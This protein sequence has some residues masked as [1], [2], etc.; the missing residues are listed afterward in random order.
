M[1]AWRWTI[2]R[3]V[4]ALAVAGLALALTIGGVSFAGVREIDTLTAQREDLVQLDTGLTRLDTKL[5]DLT[6][7]EMAAILTFSPQAATTVKDSYSGDVAD[8][9]TT[10]AQLDALHLPADLGAPVAALKTAFT[11]FVA[12]ASTSLPQLLSIPP[13]DSTAAEAAMAEQRNRTET[14]ATQVDADRELIAQR[15]AQS[16][17]VLERRIMT[18]QTTIVVAMVVGLLGLSVLSLW[19]TRLISRPVR[20]MVTALQGLAERD[21]TVSVDVRGNDEI[22]LMGTALNGAVSSVRQTVETLAS[23]STTLTAAATHLGAVSAELGDSA[24]R[25]ATQTDTIA[26]SAHQVAGSAGSM[27]AAT[28]QMSASITEIAG[29]ATRAS[30]VAGEAVRTAHE[31][32]EAVRDLG[33]ASNEIEEIVQAITSIAAQTNL[34]ALNA[35]IEAARAGDAGKGFAVVANEVK[36][37]AQETARA[38]E[39]ITSKITA[40]QSTTGRA[41]DAIARITQVIDQINENQTTIA[42]AVEEQTA[43]TSEITRNVS[44]VSGGSVHIAGTIAEIAESAASTSTSAAATQRSANDLAAL[45]RTVEGLV[46]Q[47][48]R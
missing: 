13:N 28:E 35:T 47:F 26:A 14:L 10:W 31:T 24:R 30:S 19:I 3:K 20:R 22:A 27:S 16:H 38:T 43:T 39:D 33:Q 15:S 36:E 45:S 34:L 40:I 18:V 4:A 17:A 12:K 37:L 8:V 5:S 44:D 2:G 9:D 41:S 48:T 6:T 7:D 1:A 11:A 25:T 32:S 42:A 29:Q 23:S 21:L 46:A